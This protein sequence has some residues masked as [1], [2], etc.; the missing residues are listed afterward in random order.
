[1][2]AKLVPCD[3]QG[4]ENS[5]GLFFVYRDHDPKYSYVRF[6]SVMEQE[7]GEHVSRI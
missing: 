6:R 1:M 5:A 4:K 7:E 2:D 3:Q